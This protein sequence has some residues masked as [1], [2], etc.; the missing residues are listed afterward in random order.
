MRDQ[1]RDANERGII[2][3]LE[4]CYCTV[5]QLPGG[6]GRPDLLVG[7]NISGANILLEV[8]MPGKEKLNPLQKK[9]HGWYKG[10][11]HLVSDVKT[12]VD[13][14]AQYRREAKR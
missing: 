7:D 6:N 5:D 10:R 2:D 14:V 12:A 11:A 1:K 13:I 9:W 4:A 8:K 3:A